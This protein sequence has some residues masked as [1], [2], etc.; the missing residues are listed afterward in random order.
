MPE[1]SV[2]VLNWN[3]KHFLE[4]CLTSLRK[5]TFRD[6]EVILVDNGSSDGSTDYVRT[7]FPEVRL[8][9]L[10]ENLGFCGGNLAG[11]KETRGELVVLLNNDTEAHPEWLEQLHQACLEF[12]AAGHFASKMMMFDE[13]TKID[14]CGF[15]VTS[16]GFTIDLG[17][18]EQDGPQWQEARSVF[19][20]CGG[21]AA[22][23]RRMLEDIGFL[24]TDFFMTYEDTDIAFRGQL[25]GYECRFVPRA[26]VYHR[27]RATM[28]KYPARQAFFSQRNIEY[29]YFKNLPTD[30]LLKNL[31]QRLLYEAGAGFFFF[32]QGVG[33]A[34]VRAKL[35]AAR[36]LPEILRKRQQIQS[37][38]KLSSREL[39]ARMYTDW[40]GPKVHKLLSTWRLRAST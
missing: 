5:Q 34:F 36:H 32:R 13:R 19:G 16:A 2:I 22:Y 15:A 35:D 21:A 28:T 6:F 12:P 11:W 37:K 23:R 27:Y 18:N 20:A 3:G 33:G 14:N 10:P 25:A 38:R 31:P 26:I 4:A 29:V 24:D 1:I 9:A 17:R 40:L 7:N 39:Q 8:L 30:L